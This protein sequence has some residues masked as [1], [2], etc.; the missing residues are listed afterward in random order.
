[1]DLA[2]DL[3][4]YTYEDLTLI[5]GGFSA[6]NFI[7]YT[8]S[9]QKEIKLLTDPD[10]KGHLDMVKLIG[11]CSENWQLGVVYDLEPINSLSNIVL[12]GLRVEGC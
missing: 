6:E 8:K 3:V 4:K 9:G 10:V 11:C 1:M 12:Q 2:S 5:T 7:G